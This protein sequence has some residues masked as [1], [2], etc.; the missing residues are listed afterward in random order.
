MFG[1]IDV[2]PLRSIAGV[3]ATQPWCTR[4]GALL[5][6]E[7]RALWIHEFLDTRDAVAAQL[8]AVGPP[9]FIVCGVDAGRDW[10]QLG[11]ALNW[12][13]GDC[14]REFVAYDAQVNGSQ[15]FHVGSGGVEIRR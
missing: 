4:G 13:A 11:G 6:P 8:A 7:I 9:A 10:A 2:D 15:V 3:T 14:V 1:G 5:Q 12:Q